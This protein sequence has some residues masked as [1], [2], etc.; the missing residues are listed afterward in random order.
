MRALPRKGRRFRAMRRKLSCV[1]AVLFISMQLSASNAK[2]PEAQVAT[3]D[4]AE[5]Q[6]GTNQIHS[7]QER[8]KFVLGVLE[9]QRH[10][11]TSPQHLHLCDAEWLVPVAGIGT[12]LVLTDRTAAHEMTR[13]SHEQFFSNLSNGGIGLFGLTAGSMYLMGVRNENDQLR[14]TGLLSAEAG[15]DALG[16]DEVLKLAFQRSR[17]D[18][19][20]NSGRFFQAGGGSFP[21]SHAATAFS[22]AT[23]IA[24]EYPGWGTK[25]LAY[26]AATGISVARVGAQQHFPSDVF[27]GA[28][29]GY[30][31]GRSVYKRHHNPA[32]ESYESFAEPSA[33]PIASMSSTYIELDSWIYPAVERLAALGIVRNE[34]LSLRP[35]TRMAVYDMLQNANEGDLPS[36]AAA[37]ISSL[38]A[39]LEREEALDKG[40]PNEFISLDRI[41]SRTQYISAAPLNNS[42]NFGQT[43]ADDFGRPYGKGLQQINGFESSAAHG[44]FSFLV[45]GEFQHSPSILGNSAAVQ[46]VIATQDSTPLQAFES[47]PATDTFRLLD[48]YVSMKLLGNEISGRKTKLLVGSGRW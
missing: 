43:I 42:W 14:E 19:L 39:E 4:P 24:S 2:A 33:L 40:Q 10:F 12:G 34:F 26:G 6:F 45:R 47:R 22:M 41:Y 27:I 18:Q 8:R 15:L 21:S 44:R 16:T 25:L 29:M 7:T 13:G 17:P 30:L 20:S 32:V 11:W 48:T 28:T 5:T 35:W 3:G 36:S 38:K 31:I 9:D 46:Q 37:L 23:V 1:W